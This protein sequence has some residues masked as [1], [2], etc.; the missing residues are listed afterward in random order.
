[1]NS[2]KFTISAVALLLGL[3]TALASAQPRDRDRDDRRHGGP[4]PHAQGHGP[5]DRH[6]DNRPDRGRGAG[7]DHR[8]HKGDRLPKEW[9][10]HQYVVNDWRGHHLKQP[11]RGYHWVQS[12]TDYI[13]VAIATGV[14]AQI[15]LNQ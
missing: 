5:Q 2:N 10:S 4:P 12:G 7:P 14:I 15:I 11:P 6:A 13:L 3:S 9:R 1:M 8:Y